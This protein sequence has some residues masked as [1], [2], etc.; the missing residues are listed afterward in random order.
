VGF[1][2]LQPDAPNQIFLTHNGWDYAWVAFFREPDL[3]Q[4]TVDTMADRL[5]DLSRDASAEGL[6]HYE[7]YLEMITAQSEFPVPEEMEA[8]I[9]EDLRIRHAPE[10]GWH[11]QWTFQEAPMRH[12]GATMLGVWPLSNA[13]GIWI[14]FDAGNTFTWIAF[15]TLDSDAHWAKVALEN[16]IKRGGFATAE[17]AGHMLTEATQRSEFPV[18]LVMDQP[19][20]TAIR[21]HFE[22]TMQ[23]QPGWKQPDYKVDLSLFQLFYQQNRRQIAATSQSMQR[24]MLSGEYA[25]ETD[26]PYLLQEIAM[27]GRVYCLSHAR[28]IYLQ[29][30]ALKMCDALAVPSTDEPEY[31]LEPLWVQP[32][33]PLPFRGGLVRGLFLYD[34]YNVDRLDLLKIRNAEEKEQTRRSIE[35]KHGMHQI[36]IFY[37]NPENKTAFWQGKTLIFG[38]YDTRRQLWAGMAEGYECPTGHCTVE[39]LGDRNILL[40]CDVCQK[41]FDH[42]VVWLK[43]LFWMMQGKFRRVGDTQHFEEFTLAPSSESENTPRGKHK[44]DKEKGP[45]RAKTFHAT[46]MQ[47]DASYLKPASKRGKRGSLLDTHIVLTTEEALREGAMEIDMNGVLIRDFTYRAGFT[48]HLVHPRFKKT[49]A[50]VK[51]KEDMPQLFSLATWKARQKQRME[52][53]HKQEAMYAS[54]Y[55]E[56]QEGGTV[57]NE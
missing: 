24:A 45:S 46:I 6:R 3:A 47:F 43:T 2:Q 19:T 34:I 33:A 10:S 37:D 32:L 26:D 4:R 22:A 30:S 12:I 52:A 42:W 17:R 44:K 50:T 41:E 38:E 49:E 23:P 14:T 55:E 35:R 31:P 9:Q 1:L 40:Q 39:S 56:P 48:R 27:M 28:I 11:A 7:E 13:Y 29:P 16:A 57:P 20:Q 18:P 51:A 5:A 54:A 53:L 15:Y 21:Q 25:H 36:E 8:A